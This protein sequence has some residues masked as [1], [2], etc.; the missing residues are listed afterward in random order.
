MK[1]ICLLAIVS[2][3]SAMAFSQSVVTEPVG[4]KQKTGKMVTPISTFNHAPVQKS[5]T[6]SLKSTNTTVVAKP[7]TTTHKV[8]A[9]RTTTRKTTKVSKS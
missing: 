7:V 9:R 6:T 4:V 8:V 2:F 1:K 5:T 3:F